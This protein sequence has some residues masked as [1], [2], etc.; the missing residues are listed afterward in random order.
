MAL[1]AAFGALAT[2]A[3]GGLVEDG[4][5]RVTA[6]ASLSFEAVLAAS[7]PTAP[8][9]P[10]SATSLE[11]Y[12]RTG[13]AAVRGL[14]S[15]QTSSAYFVDGGPAGCAADQVRV[16]PTTARLSVQGKGQIEIRIAGTGCLTRTPPLPL[17]A[18]ETFVV[19]G[20]S[21]TYAGAGGEGT[22][23][24]VSYGPPSFSARDTWTGTLT[25]PGLAFDLTPPVITG[26]RGKTVRAPKSAKRVRV[27]Y[28]VSA[29]DDVEGS[30]ASSCRPR[31]RSWFPVGRTRVRCSATD[32]SANEIT[33]TFV[34]TVK[35]AR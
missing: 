14:G 2:S 24:T 34:V 22:V 17:R 30:V 5:A 16:L 9:P 15:V 21:G 33:A 1:L 19:T 13:T 18:E 4:L 8:C 26:A 12:T 20:G 11:C 25:V 3:S 35:R 29:R 7:Y 32:T 23:A 6:E 31:S 28:A 10:G 27:A